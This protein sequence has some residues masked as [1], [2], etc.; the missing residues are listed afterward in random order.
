[1]T[2]VDIPIPELQLTLHQPTIKEISLLD[3]ELSYFL[4]L[5]LVGFDKR[6]LIAGQDQDNSRL[7]TMNDFDIFMTLLTDP[8]VENGAK[9][10]NDFLSVLTI[11]F[12]GYVPQLLPKSIYLNNPI[13]KH[14]VSIDENNFL[15][16]KNAIVS[17]GGLK[18][19]GAGQNGSFNPKGRKAAE[20]AAKLM[21]GRQRASAQKQE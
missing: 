5:Q 20:I 4:T 1:M 7:A 18:N 11:M 6:I 10:R 16:F 3:S 15:A 2:G 19:N 17:V 9:R 12:P 21:R 14:R 13:T 8:K